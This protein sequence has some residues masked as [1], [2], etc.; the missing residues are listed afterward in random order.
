PFLLAVPLGWVVTGEARLQPIRGG[1]CVAAI[2]VVVGMAIRKFVFNDGTAG[3]FVAVAASFF[4][5]TMVMW[6]FWAQRAT[7]AA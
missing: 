2:T 6:R 3:A 4:G 5:V 7:A 1:L